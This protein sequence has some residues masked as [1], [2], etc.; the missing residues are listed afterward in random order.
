MADDGLGNAAGAITPRGTHRGDAVDEFD[1]ANWRHLRRAVLA[2]HR[3]A[4]E[5]D[6][7]DDVMSPTDVGQQL[8]Q[9]VTPALRRVPEMMVRV[10]DRQIRLERRLAGP[11]C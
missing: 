2:V 10:D 1:L 3:A 4:L 5:E 11:L 9:Q 6:R 8:G 7:G